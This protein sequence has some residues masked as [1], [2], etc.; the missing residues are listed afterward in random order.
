M[1]KKMMKVFAIIITLC[2]LFGAVPMSASADC[3]DGHNWSEPVWTWNLNMMPYTVRA[4][5]TC[6]DCGEVSKK[7]TLN[8]TENVTKQAIYFEEGEVTYS[9]SVTGPDGKT[10][11]GTKTEIISAPLSITHDWGTSDYYINGGGAL[12]DG[13][14]AQ[15]FP[16]GTDLGD[17]KTIY[18]RDGWGFTSIG[19]ENFKDFYALESFYFGDNPISSIGDG[20]FMNTTSLA[21][22]NLPPTLKTIGNSA[23]EFSY[24]T[25]GVSIRSNILE[26]IG[27]DAF[28]FTFLNKITLPGSVSYIGDDAFMLLGYKITVNCPHDSYAMEYAKERAYPVIGTDEHTFTGTTTW[29][30]DHSDCYVDLLCEGC[31]YH[32]SNLSTSISVENYPETDRAD[33]K[34]VY[35]AT[36][37]LDHG[38]VLDVTDTVGGASKF[39][40]ITIDCGDVGEDITIEVPRGSNFFEALWNSGVFSTLDA[41]ENEDYIFRDL[42]TKPIS[43][44]SDLDEFNEDAGALLES[45]VESDM[46]VYAGFYTKIKNVTLT[47]EQP[48]I[49]T[50]VTITDGIQSP[51][52]V[53]SCEEGEKY[54]I[55]T[56]FDYQHSVW[57]TNDD[58]NYVIFEGA[59]EKGATYW[60]DLLVEPDFG[61]WLDDNTVVTANGATVEMSMGPMVLSVT[62]S[63]QAVYPDILGD[64]DG[65]GEVE[66]ID[67]TIIQRYL[68]DMTVPYTE[69][70]LM[71]G[72]VDG[73]G[74]LSI[75]DATLIQRY[76][77]GFSVAYPIGEIIE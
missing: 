67:A 16:E 14:L 35:I 19:A 41:M 73:D 18:L 58:D 55:Y 12:P 61:Y 37:Y 30:D 64:A 77:A 63:T 33:A 49:G 75:I 8:V 59:F 34:T 69:D 6:A 47:L 76:N 50:T 20:A 23:F 42:I 15:Y 1:K 5:F 40:V 71:N 52:P 36:F 27:E 21:Y 45:T 38:K 11:T 31:G 28:A 25:D 70:E 43:E 2:V 48:V 65:N 4:E 46:T 39:P 44:F 26:S 9:A 24:L 54:S 72:D 17:V 62:L 32:Y 74:E 7:V 3:T 66:I 60:T 13:S 10:Y 22:I 29:A 51:V 68:S 56:D 53:L 57:Y